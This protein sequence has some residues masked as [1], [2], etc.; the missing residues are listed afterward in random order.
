M[1][2]LSWV[3]ERA[4]SGEGNTVRICGEKTELYRE[5]FYASLPY[6][7]T[8]QGKYTP[9]LTTVTHKEK[10]PVSDYAGREWD[11]S[12]KLLEGITGQDRPT[13]VW[14]KW[15]ELAWQL[16]KFL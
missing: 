1:A 3:G 7:L 2:L 12:H 10:K 16:Y 11:D 5:D 4:E 8:T 6:S 9:R 14:T 15:K 13:Q